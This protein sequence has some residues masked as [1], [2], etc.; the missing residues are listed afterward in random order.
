MD[1]AARFESV[2]AALRQPDRGLY[3]APIRHHSPACAWAVRELI[4]DVRPQRVL[5]D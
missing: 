1:D 3:F 4:R 5:I 2:R